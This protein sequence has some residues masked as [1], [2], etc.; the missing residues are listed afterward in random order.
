MLP[1]GEMMRKDGYLRVASAIPN[2]KIAD[3][4]ANAHYILKSAEDAYVEGA[5]IVLFPELS[6][7][8]YTCADLFH[9]QKLRSESIDALRIIAGSDIAKKITIIVGL[10]LSYSGVLY[11]CAAVVDNGKIAGIVPKSY[12]PNYGEYYEK[13]WFSSGASL[14]GKQIHID[15]EE[16]PFG[17]DLLFKKDEATIGLEICEDLWVPVPPSCRAALNGAN[18]IFNLSATNE[19]VGKNAYLLE[20][21]RQQSARLR[22]AYIYSSAGFGESSTDL[23]FSGNAII[24]ENG[25]IICKSQR[26]AKSSQVIVADID[27]QLLE[28][29][30]TV[31]S[32]F[33]DC[34]FR[35]TFNYREVRLKSSAYDDNSG[36]PNKNLLRHIDRFPFVPQNEGLR[37]ERC[38]EI[39]NIQVEGLRRRL[40]VFGDAKAVIGI[41][42]GLDSTLALL[43]TVEAF[44]RLGLP[45]KNVYGITMPGFGTT[46][47][48]KNNADYMM[49]SLGVTALEITIAD[50]ARNHLRDIDHPESI[51]DATYENSQARERTQVLM[52]YANKVG[53]I[54]VGTGDLS[55]L[56]LGWCTYNGDH[57]SMYGVNVSIPKTLVRHLV[58][59]FADK[60]DDKMLSKTLIDVLDTPVSPELIPAEES[61][62]IGQKTE[63]IVGPYELHDFFLYHI[64]RHGFSAE[65][66]YRLAVTAFADTYTPETIKKWLSTFLRRF[67]NQQFKRSCM[68]DGPKVG[69]VCLSPRGDWRMPSDV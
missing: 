16:I 67:Y 7:T 23:V 20:L 35:D 1:W 42:G 21:I 57:M 38:S 10:P 18:M 63:D 31:A 15:D 25:K 9:Q 30:R 48:T 58:K 17:V 13:R 61:D 5:S 53:G 45:R 40:S 68:P 4:I 11:N 64:L 69:S 55:E 34:A 39:I 32:S 51:H 36:N 27:T 46:S 22:A 56:A 8:S 2:V 29:E 49:E 54:V 60:T 47:R 24:A 33:A 43:V 66:I 65:K 3:S 41:S 14:I 37:D 52:D 50:A 28:R 44:D 12:L 26:F 6:L 59:W 62:V 19:V